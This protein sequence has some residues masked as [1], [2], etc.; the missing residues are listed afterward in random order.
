MTHDLPKIGDI[1]QI[2]VGDH[3][4]VDF[5]LVL[6][7]EKSRRFGNSDFLLLDTW[8]FSDNALWLGYEWDWAKSSGRNITVFAGI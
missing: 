6:K 5:L 2:S 7:V 4:D 8:R 3:V 1:I